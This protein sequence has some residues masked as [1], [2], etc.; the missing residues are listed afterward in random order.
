MNFKI[1]VL[2]GDGIG[3]EVCAAAVEVLNKIGRK[4]GHAFDFTHYLIGGCAI[5]GTTCFRKGRKT[6][7]WE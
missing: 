2:D 4:Y 7:F 3:P 5:N 1:A 6:G